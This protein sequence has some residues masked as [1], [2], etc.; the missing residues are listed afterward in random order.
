M[1]AHPQGTVS[2]VFTD[3]VGST[4]L[5]ERHPLAM[6]G[7]VRD[8]DALLHGIFQQEGGYVFKTVGDAFCVAFS[9]PSNALRAVVR[10][11][12]SLGSRDWGAL[13]ALRW[14]LFWIDPEPDRA[15]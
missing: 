4:R 14:R 9:S 13:G 8:H 10:V 2:F 5:W 1:D 11:Q 12:T 3:I 15:H 7:A 6:G